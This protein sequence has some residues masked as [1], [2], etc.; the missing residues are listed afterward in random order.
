MPPKIK[1]SVKNSDSISYE[2]GSPDDSENLDGDPGAADSQE[3]ESKKKKK[4]GLAR[5]VEELTAEKSI[6][7]KILAEHQEE[8]AEM[9][10]VLEGLCRSQLELQNKAP[11]SSSLPLVEDKEDGE[12]PEE[13]DR[14]DGD[15]SM[16]R[17]NRPG[18]YF[19]YKMGIQN[20]YTI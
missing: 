15:H 11:N 20:E 19:V 9:R 14:D 4:G 5:R 6:M 18:T 12:E 8:M 3:D 10:R 1:T 7:E 17:Q 2:A 16:H 13:D